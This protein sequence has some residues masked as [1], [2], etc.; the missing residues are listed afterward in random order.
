[1]K[2]LFNKRGV[3]LALSTVVIMAILLLVAVIV[4]SFFLGATGKIFGPLS[5]LLGTGAENINKSIQQ[6]G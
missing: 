6:L 3:E 4:I 2:L 5:N 1:M